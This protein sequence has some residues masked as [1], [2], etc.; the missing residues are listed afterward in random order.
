MREDMNNDRTRT[1]TDSQINLGTHPDA[2]ITVEAVGQRL[3]QYEVIA[4]IGEGGIGCVFKARHRVLNRSVALKVLRGEWADD[5][6]F[7]ERFRREAST[8]A[9][10]NHPGIVAIHDYGESGDLCYIAMELVDGS[11]L[12]QLMDA[13][14]ITPGRVLAIAGDLCAA[15]SAA[16]KCGIVHRDIKPS[17]IVI[18]KQGRL[19]LVD[20]GLSKIR[21]PQSSEFTLTT[22]DTRLGTPAYVAPEQWK[23][24]QLADERADI[25]ALGVVIYE[26]LAGGKPIGNFPLASAKAGLSPRVDAVLSK[27]MQNDPNLRY[28]S[29]EDFHRD[30]VRA[31]RKKSTV[32]RNSLIA[33]A[34]LVMATASAF[35]LPHINAPA[36]RPAHIP[37]LTNFPSPQKISTSPA[38]PVS[39]DADSRCEY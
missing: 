14:E 27:A 1:L 18:D 35:I 21:Q 30:L 6:T 12:R 4:A 23:N 11:T 7:I 32:A 36:R 37:A 15:L 33:A 29:V 5:P 16:H 26:M 38:A 9:N 3:R 2:G 19:K 13:G 34:A 24:P 20:F 17:N 10:L 25:F 31:F 39:D 22:P 8:L 28:A